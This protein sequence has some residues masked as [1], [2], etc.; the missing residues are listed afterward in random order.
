MFEP[1]EIEALVAGV[2]LVETWCGPGLA[3]AARSALIRIRAAVPAK[4][5][6]HLDDARVFAPRFA[7]GSSPQ[8]FEIAH[9]GIAESR[10]LTIEYEG[11][12]GMVSGRTIRPLGLYFWGRF[13][14]LAAWCEFRHDFRNFRLDRIRRP[15]LR[16]AF[17]E[18]PDKTL[19][20][21]LASRSSA[22]SRRER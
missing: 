15:S 21:F 6:A 12:D 17:V 7:R 8:H 4:L 13:W 22:A 5:I 9:R 1:H 2:R 19:A 11:E 10:R 14:T 20:L 16:E 3:A 18:E